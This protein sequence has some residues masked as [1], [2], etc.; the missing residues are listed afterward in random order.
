MQ[1]LWETSF[2]LGIIIIALGFLVSLLRYRLFDA[3]AFGQGYGEE[4]DFCH[5]ASA[6][7]W[8][9]LLSCSPFVSPPFFVL[10]FSLSSPHCR[11]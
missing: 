10:F 1:L 3:E 8:R 5:R 9:H 4:T 11:Q 6:H 7:G 2:Q